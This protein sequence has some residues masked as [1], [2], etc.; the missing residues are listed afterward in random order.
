MIVLRKKLIVERGQ[1]WLFE[2]DHYVFDITNDWTT[3]ASEIG[4]LA[5]DRC[6]QENLIAQWKG[7]VKALAMPVGNLVSNRAYMVRRAWRGA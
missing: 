4:F 7:R 3:A 5:D 1:F 6:D 2:P